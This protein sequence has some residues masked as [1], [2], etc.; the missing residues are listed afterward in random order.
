MSNIL[1]VTWDGGGNVPPATALAHELVRRGHDVRV[2]GH[3]PQEEAMAAE[4]L[5]F[6][7]PRHARP[8]ERYSPTL[9][10]GCLAGVT[11]AL[12]LEWYGGR[13][14]DE[15][16]EVVERA[17]E[18]F[19]ASTTRDA[20]AVSRWDDRELEA[21]GPVTAEVRRVWRERERGLLGL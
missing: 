18:V 3:A 5:R 1:F 2:L 20:Q 10:S 17:S 19:L 8:L 4:G 15:T 11:R 7:R 16:I 6:V 12:I 13:E 9:A 14:V 21:P